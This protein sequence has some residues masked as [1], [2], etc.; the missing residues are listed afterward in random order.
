MTVQRAD[1]L[2]LDAWMEDYTLD[3]LWSMGRLGGRS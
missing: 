1:S 3:Q 2:D